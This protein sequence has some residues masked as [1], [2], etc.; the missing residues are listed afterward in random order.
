[1]QYYLSER[2]SKLENANLVGVVLAMPDYMANHHY[3]AHI[4]VQGIKC[5]SI[6]L[7]AP[8]L[9]VENSDL[10]GNLIVPTSK[11]VPPGCEHM[12]EL[13]CKIVV[14]DSGAEASLLADS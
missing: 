3:P 10:H 6:H 7:S 1:M 13:P 8:L 2:M 4:Y 5:L 14:F 11:S 9:G 12:I